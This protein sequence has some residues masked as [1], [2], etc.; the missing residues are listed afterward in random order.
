VRVLVTGGAGFIGSHVVDLLVERGHEVVVLDNLDP[1]VHGAGATEPHHI[2]PHV[3][4][5]DVQFLLGDVTRR[6][7]VSAA[8]EGVDAVVHL[9]AAVGVGQSMYSPYYYVHTNSTGSGL[10]LDVVVQNRERVRK[11]VVASSMSLYGEGAYRCSTCGKNEARARSE[12]QLANA[13]WEVICNGCEGAMESLPTPETKPPEIASVY[14]ASKKNQEELF[15]A[16]GRAYGIPTFALR[17]FNVFG[18]RQSLNNPYTGVAAI[19]LSRLLNG[20]RPVVFEDG[21]QSRDFIDV[22]DV[23]QA[24]CSAVETEKPGVHVLNVG[25][26]RRLSILEVAHALGRA[27]GMDGSPSVLGRYRAGDIRHCISDPTEARSILGFEARRRF[28]DALPELIAWCREQKATD[29]FER[30]LSELSEKGLV[31]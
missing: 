2:Q 22:R 6:D 4:R 14:A 9:A 28:E 24:V 16:F 10:V 31:R 19:F 27:L 26:G 20:H 7:D 21:Q 29:R 23:A 25:T 15:V 17:F 1:Q 12:S 5:G 3:T 11:L 18:P 30:S 8:I 13:Q